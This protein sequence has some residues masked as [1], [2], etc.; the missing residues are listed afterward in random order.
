MACVLVVPLGLFAVPIDTRSVFEAKQVSSSGG[1]TPVHQGLQMTIWDGV[2]TEEQAKRGR[3]IYLR[4]C[5]VCHGGDLRGADGP[6][7]VG[8]EFSNKWRDE[9]V[10]RMFDTTRRTMPQ[11]N[12]DSLGSQAYIDLISFLL[13]ANGS[14]AG[15]AELPLDPEKLEQILITEKPF[16]G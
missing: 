2:Y 15:D 6:A 10:A 13:K 5:G 12:P 3:E 14:P 4:A 11:D 1:S 8:S 16:P 7:L 9:P